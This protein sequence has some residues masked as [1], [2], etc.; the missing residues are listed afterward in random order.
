MR[1]F[2]ELYVGRTDTYGTY[3]LP[4]GQVAK[5][6]TKFLGKAETVSG[7]ELT[8]D[9]YKAHL[10]G[11]TGLG[12]V[13]I[14]PDTN[15]VNWFAIDVDEYNMEDIHARMANK[16][17]RLNLPLVICNS[18]SGGA[19][20]YCFLKRPAPAAECIKHA[21]T[22]LK[23]LGLKPT[24]EIFPKQTTVRWEDTGSWI[25]LPYFGQTRLCM[26]PDGKTELTLKEF[27]MFVETMEVDPTDLDI[28]ISE[29]EHRV[30]PN[31]SKNPPC[32]DTMTEDGVEEGGR[33]DALT[34]YSIFAKRALPDEWQ[35]AVMQFNQEHVSPPLTFSEVTRI[36]KGAERKEYQYF[37]TKAP[38][39][40]ICDKDACLKREFGIG[41]EA[42]DNREEFVIDNIRKIAIPDDPVYVVVINGKPMRMDLDTMLTWRLFKRKYF[43]AMN[44][45]PKPMKQEIW[46]NII[47]EAMDGCEIED[48]P[49]IVSLGGQVRHAFREWTSRRITVDEAS[50]VEGYPYYD[51]SKEM[52]VFRGTDFTDYLRR[53]GNRF[54][55]R[56]VW[57]V[58]ECEGATD[59][60]RQIGAAKVK[61]IF[62]PA[63]EQDLW[64]DKPTEGQ[65]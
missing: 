32:I 34:H 48:A 26:G 18:K 36:I 4:K 43:D 52:I 2:H 7:G 27:L 64:F 30:D 25:N 24:T 37:C 16:I 8:I 23:K 51:E 62:F 12:I 61:V 17:N 47:N 63:E 6:G 33:D 13:P 45:L 28:R 59:A 55:P 19:H 56:D 65:F 1:K 15:T 21:K 14:V 54:N 40:G 53:S 41:N 11:T 5:R 44:Q 38:M 49:E 46:E 31:A 3:A 20:L 29:I 58:L 50:I 35:D 22:Y 10:S 42:P 9:D 39:N 60:R 57:S